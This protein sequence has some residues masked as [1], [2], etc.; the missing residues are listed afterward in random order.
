MKFSGKIDGGHDDA[1]RDE[2]KNTRQRISFG[3]DSDSAAHHVPQPAS[4]TQ[5]L[6]Q[7][8]GDGEADGVSMDPAVGAG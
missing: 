8:E 3:S 5:V 1:E 6:R 2:A 7:R 4:S